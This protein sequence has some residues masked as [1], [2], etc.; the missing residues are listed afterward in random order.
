MPKVTSHLHYRNIDVSTIKELVRRWYP[1]EYSEAPAKRFVHKTVA[2]IEDSIAEL[3]YYRS[4]IFKP[5]A[6]LGVDSKTL[7]AQAQRK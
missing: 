5:E 6:E 3:K 2:D 7:K 1:K 4:V